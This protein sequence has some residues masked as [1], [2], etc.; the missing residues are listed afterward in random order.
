[1]QRFARHW[2]V[3]LRA[4]VE[5]ELG[6]YEDGVRA[7]LRQVGLGVFGRASGPHG[8]FQRHH[9]DAITLYAVPATGP[10]GFFHMGRLI[11]SFVRSMSNLLERLH[12][13]QFF[14]LLLNPRRF[15]PIGTA[16]LIPLFLSIAL[17]IGGLALW[18]SEE[19][20]S[21]Q[22]RDAVLSSLGQTLSQAGDVQPEVPTLAWYRERLVERYVAG[23]EA[24]EPS[25]GARTIKLTS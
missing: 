22:E 21:R 18:F 24:D 6:N 13:S 20:A 3:K 7:A 25:A 9:V 12:H 1:M 2:G 15:V 23:S 16:I 8:F 17:T 5:Y 10:Y 11:E 4:D 14:Y 19:K